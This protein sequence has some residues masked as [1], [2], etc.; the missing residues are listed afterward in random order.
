M[1]RPPILL[2]LKVIPVLRD[3]LSVRT[4]N[5][6]QK[7]NP[8]G[9][10]FTADSVL[11]Y[12]NTTGTDTLQ[13][14]VNAAISQKK[15]LFIAAGTYD[16]PASLNITGAVK[17]YG[18][19]NGT[20]LK[21]P[22]GATQA[23]IINIG[24]SPVGNRI[25]DISI[26]G[27]TIQ[28]LDLAISGHNA[29]SNP[30]GLITARKVDRLRITECFIGQ[31]QG[32]GI[33]LYETAG[34]IEA[35]EFWSCRTGIGSYL[36]MGLV[37]ERNYIRDSK[38]NG[39]EINR[40][41]PPTYLNP[42]YEGAV[43]RANKIYT[44]DNATGG[45][46]QYGNGIICTQAGGVTVTGNLISATKYSGVRLNACSTSIVSDNQ[47][48]AARETALFVESLGPDVDG[49]KGVTVSGN[50][51]DYSGSGI[52]VTNP[53]NGAR[54]VSVIGNSISN[55]QSNVFDEWE[56]ADRNP[57]KRYTQHSGTVGIA[58]EGAN[59]VVEGNTIESC[60]S[61]GVTLYSTGDWN[62]NSPPSGGRRTN[63]SVV[64]LMNNNIIRACPTGIGY[65]MNDTRGYAEI[66]GNAIIGST[67][68]AIVPVHKTDIPATDNPNNLTL[69][70]AGPWVRDAG[71]AD[72]GSATTAITQRY[73][74][75]RN[76]VIAA[77]SA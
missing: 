45:S 74:F 20:I 18:A 62:P 49:Y 1:F 56:S 43:I 31:S 57:A 67:N 14:A 34:L 7:E 6:G 71:S 13:S 46:G 50:I 72:I 2:S 29:W 65:S 66:A 21:P 60:P 30:L 11:T 12:N 27:V 19:R 58:A 35:N 15:P 51:I 59:I 39:I 33:Q 70:M 63:N 38:D 26:E 61:F 75:D 8:M 41:A 17:I 5:D 77:T 24:S 42:T 4:A 25:S 23:S 16:M 9:K 36:G 47:I 32:A 3:G 76:K 68:G 53:L 52:C 44:V 48:Y 28:G 10:L 73:S 54:R 64:I 69:V 37:I 40:T 55:L 22:A